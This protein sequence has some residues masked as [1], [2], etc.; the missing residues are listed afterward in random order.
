MKTSPLES[1]SAWVDRK[2]AVLSLDAEARKKEEVLQDLRFQVKR[3]TASYSQARRA[4]ELAARKLDVERRKEAILQRQMDLG[5]VKRIDY[6]QGAIETA[7]A[8]ID[9]AE[10]YLQL[11][12]REHDWETL[13]GMRP[14]GLRAIMQKERGSTK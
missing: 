9:L 5:E 1:I 6:L 10:S 4:I 12:E 13:L 2:T 7:T 11:L 8:E 3:L 14:G